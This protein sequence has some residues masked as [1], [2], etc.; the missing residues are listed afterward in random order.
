[1]ILQKKQPVY[2][3]QMA[4]ELLTKT[5]ESPFIAILILAKELEESNQANTIDSDALKAH[6]FPNL[7]SLVCENL[8][9]KLELQGYLVKKQFSFELTLKGNES[10]GD[11]SMWIGEKGIYNVYTT[12][13]PFTEQTIIAIEWVNNNAADTRYLKMQTIS[14]QLA[15]YQNKEINLKNTF[16]RIEKMDTQCFELP[17]ENWILQLKAQPK[18]Q[19]ELSIKT[20]K[21]AAF[22]EEMSFDFD[23][24]RDSLLIEKFEE[25]YVENNIL[26]PFDAENLNFVRDIDL[27]KPVFSNEVF[28]KMQLKDII[29]RPQTEQDAVVWYTYLLSQ[30]IENYF[31]SD[32]EFNVFSA[33]YAQKFKRHFD[34][35]TIERSELIEALKDNKETFYLRA[36]LE[37]IDFLNY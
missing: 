6:L 22:K 34:L 31:L 5:K 11:K 21:L 2:V 19:V 12:K 10:A 35:Y 4:M 27:E 33:E 30:N 3:H 15:Y 25:N 13:T 36:K 23:D 29:H 24:L 20:E 18:Q 16:Y 32:N 37:T 14:K 28:D 1:M 7:P 26:V 17:V 8:L 9:I